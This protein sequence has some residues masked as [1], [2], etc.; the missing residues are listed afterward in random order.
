MCVD[1]NVCG[2]VFALESEGAQKNRG[3]HID[4]PGVQP[5]MHSVINRCRYSPPLALFGSQTSHTLP[6]RS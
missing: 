3:D 1:T 2:V 5:V 4:H 6:T